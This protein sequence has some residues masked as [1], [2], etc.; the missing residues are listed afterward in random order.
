MKIEIGKRYWTRS[1]W[2]SPVVTS[3]AD[4]TFPFIAGENT[5]RGNGWF[6]KHG[7]DENDLVAEYTGPE[8]VPPGEKV[9]RTIVFKEVLQRFDD[10]WMLGWESGQYPHEKLVSPDETIYTG[11]ER[12]VKV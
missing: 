5:Y 9:K 4:D 12:V 1:G 10:Y 2:V 7:E 8:P 6:Y 3:N 11:N